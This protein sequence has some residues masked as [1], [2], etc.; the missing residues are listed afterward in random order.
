MA[1]VLTDFCNVNVVQCSVYLIQN[2]K[3]CGMKAVSRP[4]QCIYNSR[5]KE[6]MM[7]TQYRSLPVNAEQQSQRSYGL[8]AT[9]KLLHV[10]KSTP[11]YYNHSLTGKRENQY[12]KRFIG[13]IAVK[14]TPP[15]YGSSMF[16]RVSDALPPAH[17]IAG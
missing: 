13:G 15:K 2:E 9:R 1:D 6:K 7:R 10:P 12:L 11:I 14:R 16:S 3:W 17:T 5:V 4:T 8:F